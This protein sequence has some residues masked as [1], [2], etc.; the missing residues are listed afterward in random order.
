M[1][2]TNEMINK[3]IKKQGILFKKAIPYWK[4]KTFKR[5]NYIQR[6]QV[7]K[8]K[9]DLNYEELIIKEGIRFCLYSRKGL[10]EPKGVILYMHGGGYAMGAPEN[11]DTFYQKL[12][13]ELDVIIVAPDYSLSL[14]EPYPKALNECFEVLKWIDTNDEY[15]FDKTKIILA[16]DSAGG[17]LCCALSIYARDHS[18]INILCQVPLYPMIDSSMSSKS[19]LNNDAPVWNTLSSEIAWKLYLADNEIDCYNSPSTLKD[20]KGLPPLI[21]FVGTL[22]PFLDETKEYVSKLEAAGVETKLLVLKGCYHGF[23]RMVPKAEVSR[24]AND[25]VIEQLTRYLNK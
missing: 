18:E 10:T 14:T 22:D 12:C 17:G 7:G 19:A 21:T 23:E 3:E 4:E 11:G 8:C 25:F 20:F 6:M 24:K 2:V 16:G 9:L 5:M 15:M 1:K 13:H